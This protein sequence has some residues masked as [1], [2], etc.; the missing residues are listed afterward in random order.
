MSLTERGPRANNPARLPALPAS[1]ATDPAARQ[2]QEAV[3]EW[4]EVRLGA[5]GDFYER[6]VTHRELK[7]LVDELQAKITALETA[8]AAAL[9]TAGFTE[10]LNALRAQLSQVTRMASLNYNNTL[11]QINQVSTQVRGVSV[12]DVAVFAVDMR[13]TQ[14]DG[15]DAITT[16]E[17]GPNQPNFHALLFP[18]GVDTSADFHCMLPFSWAGK[19][20]RCYVYW[21]HG[22]GGTDFDVSWEIVANTTYD[23]ETVI[24]DFVPG[25]PFDDT[26]GTAGNLYIAQS[27]DVPIASYENEEGSLVSIRVYRRGATSATDNLD[28]DAA[29]LAVRFTLADV[30][31]VVPEPSPGELYLRFEGNFLDS[32][33]AARTVTDHG[34]ARSTSYPGGGVEGLV[35]NGSGWLSVVDD[36]AFDIGGRIFQIRFLLRIETSASLATDNIIIGKWGATDGSWFVNLY[37]TGRLNLGRKSGSYF[38]DAITDVLP[39]DTTLQIT[40]WRPTVNGDVYCAVDGSIDPTYGIVGSALVFDTTSNDLAIG[41]VIGGGASL[42]AG[43]H[44][45][46]LQFKIDETDYGTSGFVPPSP[47]YE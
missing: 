28:I 18:P 37:S 9:K 4:L 6:A 7:A 3:R 23:N 44:V 16:V 43:V 29:L 12:E 21:G 5:R 31:V 32:S 35:G 42:P 24:L 34:A 1:L 33:I 20:F 17:F 2:W 19:Y 15:C 27:G 41:A 22:S 39:R 45:D 38:F 13:P 14:T 8:L 10:Q 30:P 46:E 47:P 25:I 36:G 11:T 40:V 26:G